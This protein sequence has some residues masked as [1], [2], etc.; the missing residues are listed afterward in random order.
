MI[1]F[2]V[3]MF[4]VIIITNYNVICFDCF[5]VERMYFILLDAKLLIRSEK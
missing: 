1:W 4:D 2:D 3:P 5:Q